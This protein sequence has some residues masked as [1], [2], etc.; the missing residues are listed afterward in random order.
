LTGV[1][2]IPANG[3]ISTFLHQIPGLDKV[4][5]PFTGTIRVTSNVAVSVLG[6]RGRYNEAASFLFTTL[7]AI[8][9]GLTTQSELIF[10]HLADGAGYTTQ[11]ILMETGA[12]TSGGSLKFFN[13]IGQPLALRLQ[14]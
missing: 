9:E 3:Q 11:F 12:A 7:P 10:P 14:N 5:L 8:T 1:V 2:P 6:L 13:P 4:T